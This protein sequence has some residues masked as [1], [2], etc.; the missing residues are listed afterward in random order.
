MNRTEE[1]IRKNTKIISART[2]VRQATN[3]SLETYKGKKKE[4]NHDK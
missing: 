4:K 2:N 3:Y 1:A